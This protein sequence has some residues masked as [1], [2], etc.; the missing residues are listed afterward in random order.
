METAWRL[1]DGKEFSF[2]VLR[3]RYLDN[4]SHAKWALASSPFWMS[5]RDLVDNMVE[6]SFSFIS[7]GASTL[8]WHDDWLGY[9]LVDKLGIPDFM[10]MF[11]NQAIDDYYFDRIWHFTKDFVVRFSDV[12]VDMLLLP[13]GEEEDAHYWKLSATGKVTSALAYAEISQSFPKV[14]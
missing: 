12:V 4:F 11:L 9:K 6:N 10:H 13:I 2:D 1:I 7:T 8:F 14:R 5:I 3:T